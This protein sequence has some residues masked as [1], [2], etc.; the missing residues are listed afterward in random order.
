ML[1]AGTGEN[2]STPADGSSDAIYAFDL[3][4]GEV[5]WKRQVTAN[6]AW[7]LTCEMEGKLSCP[8]ED[9]PDY[10]FGASP[11]LIDLAD[12]RQMLVAGQKSGW[13]YG[14]DPD[15]QGEV[16]WRNRVGRGG[17]QGGIHFGIAAE[18]AKVYVPVTDFDGPPPFGDDY[19]DEKPRPGIYAIDANNG[20]FIWQAPHP[21]NVCNGREFCDPGVSAAITSLPDMVL[22]GGMDGVLR[23]HDGADGSILW[24][25][26][27]AVDYQTVNGVKGK[28]GSFGGPGPTVI[29]GTIYVNSGYGLY[30]HMPGNVLLAFSLAE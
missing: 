19:G 27:T 17:V 26:N 7:N 16:V 12:D 3:E 21:T 2:Y 1:Y 11:I 5:R 25:V 13:V 6:D 29:D 9:G 18:G 4:T 24:Q 30:F 8:K 20:E 23:A 28:G 22:S 14:M 10:D 15:K